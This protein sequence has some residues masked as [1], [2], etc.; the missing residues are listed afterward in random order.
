MAS[1]NEAE[2]RRVLDALQAY[3]RA[4]SAFGRAFATHEGMHHTDAAAIV[5]IITAEDDG[6]PLTPARLAERV[7]LTAGATST[8]LNRLESNGYVERTREHT[9]RR[10]VTLRSAPRV[11]EA[12][13]RFREPVARRLEDVLRGRP[14]AE[15]RDLAALLDDLSGVLRDGALSGVLRDGAADGGR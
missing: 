8:L 2:H 12:A 6:E 5:E 1:S 10:L 15:L 14:V 4:N 11:H 3:V 9:D 13:A 7:M